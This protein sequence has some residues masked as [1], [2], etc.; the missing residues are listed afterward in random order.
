[1]FHDSFIDLYM[2]SR[3]E[4]NCC[5][6]IVAAT[7]KGIAAVDAKKNKNHQQPRHREQPTIIANHRLIVVSVAV[8]VVLV[9]VAA[10]VVWLI[11][12]SL[13]CWLIVDFLLT[14]FWICCCA[15]SGCDC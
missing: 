14:V 3:N 13:D 4:K 1:M 5:F 12:V 2:H 9:V 11:V 10:I 7:K 15:A 8:L 6:T